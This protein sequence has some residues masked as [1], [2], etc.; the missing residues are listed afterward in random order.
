MYNDTR[1]NIIRLGKGD[2]LVSNELG[3]CWSKTSGYRI[4]LDQKITENSIEPLVRRNEP[5]ANCQSRLEEVE[6]ETS[7]H[8]HL[9]CP[10]FA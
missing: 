10:V 3:E 6:I 1:Q 5:D 8:F 4:L 7:R 2:G 9:Y